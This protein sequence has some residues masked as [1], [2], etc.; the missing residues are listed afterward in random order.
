MSEYRFTV[1]GPMEEMLRVMATQTPAC[2][3]WPVHVKPSISLDERDLHNLMTDWH[4]DRCAVCARPARTLRLDH[5]HDTGLV[6]GWLCTGCNLS[7][8]HGG[9][10][11]MDRYREKHPT[12]MLGIRLPYSG[13]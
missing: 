9:G 2:W 3:S 13:R 6:R 11:I 4:R 10:L 7:E 8:G 1:T 5:D 12:I